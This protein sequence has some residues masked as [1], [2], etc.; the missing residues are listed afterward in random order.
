MAGGKM[1]QPAL[2]TPFDMPPPRRRL[3]ADPTDEDLRLF[4]G[5]LAIAA[6]ATALLVILSL[7]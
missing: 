7:R 6:A 1:T 3:A 5:L 2:S 4:L